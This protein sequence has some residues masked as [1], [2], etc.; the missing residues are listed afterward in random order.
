MLMVFGILDLLKSIKLYLCKFFEKKKNE[1]LFLKLFLRPSTWDILQDTIPTSKD[2][3]TS[4]QG[5][6]TQSV[7]SDALEHSSSQLSEKSKGLSSHTHAITL[8]ACTYSII[9]WVH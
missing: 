9:K 8:S 7:D 1:F 5:T 3:N 2:P 6:E 4:I